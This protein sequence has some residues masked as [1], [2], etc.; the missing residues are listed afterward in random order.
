MTQDTD[1]LRATLEAAFEGGAASADAGA[2]ANDVQADAGAVQADN[3]GAQASGGAEDREAAGEPAKAPEGA[4]QIA[5]EEAAAIAE[6]REGETT[7]APHSLPAPVKAKWSSLD[8]DVRAAFV[9]LE[10]STQAAKGEWAQKAERLNRLDGVLAPRREM[11]KIRGLDEAQAIQS[12]FA[13]QDLLERNPLEGL[14]YLARSYS[15]NLAQLAQMSGQGQGAQQ[16][17]L[18]PAHLQPILQ[19]VQ[20]LQQQ[21]DARTQADEAAR[22]GE[23]TSQIEAFRSDPANPYFDNVKSRMQALIASG[24]ASTLAEAYETACWVDP[25]I[26]PLLIQQNQAQAQAKAQGQAERERAAR[27]KQ[28]AGSV[29]GAPGGATKLTPAGSTGSIRDDLRAAWDSHAA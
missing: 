13:A 7:R 23:A 19:Q 1:D 28:A 18:P 11:L 17:A 14:S 29:T 4:E 10:E 25:E 21:L 5:V 16:Q 22:L 6:P 26:R 20:T 24:Q 27:A 12:L 2:P 9:R 15:V 8:P 3:E